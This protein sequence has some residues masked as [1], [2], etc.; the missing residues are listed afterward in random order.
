[1]YVLIMTHADAENVTP[2]HIFR[3]LSN[4]GKDDVNALADRFNAVIRDYIPEL[5]KDVFFDEIL[6]SSFARC[7][8]TAIQFAAKVNQFTGTS[9]IKL[10]DQLKEKREGNLTTGDIVSVLDS[11]HSEVVL[12]CV[13]GDLAG[14]MPVLRNLNPDYIVQDKKRFFFLGKPVWT[15][16]K[17]TPRSGDHKWENAEVLLCELLDNDNWISIIR[18]RTK[19]T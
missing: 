1:M 18:N 8:E 17:F 19:A 3:P 4:K 13:H 11:T 16:I 2:R 5:G 12:L 9:E 6:S 7:I 15:L 14:A 10:A